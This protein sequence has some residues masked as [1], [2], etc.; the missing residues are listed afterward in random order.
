MGPSWLRRCASTPTHEVTVARLG[1]GHSNLTYAVRSGDQHWVLR[2]PPAGPLLPT[3][4]DVVREYRVLDLLARAEAPVRV[5]RPVAV[6]E[7]A[8]CARR[9][10]LPDGARRGRR[11]ARR[12]CRAGSTSRA[13]TPSV[14]TWPT[15]FAEVHRVDRRAVRR[16][17][18]RPRR[19]ATWHGSCAGGP[20]SERAS[21]PR[22]PRPGDGP[23]TLPDYDRV[24][25]WLARPPARRGRPAVVHGDAKLDNVVVGPGETPQ[26]SPPSSTGR[27]PPSATRGPTW[28]TCCRSGRSPASDHPL[29]ELVTAGAGVPEPRRAGRGL[30]AGDR[31]DGRATSPGSSRWPIWKLAVLLEASYHRHLA[32]STDDPFFATLEHGVPDLLA[33]ARE[34]CGA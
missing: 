18:A 3:A 27:W 4:H 12:R 24:R 7:D 31:P 6:C 13:G 8:E 32:G 19:A 22:S 16:R 25:D 23:A 9:A 26:R 5:P 21:R 14:S 20:G 28:A 15:A 10:V 1:E 34:I 29:A 11:G 33:H 17:R 30:G 2:R